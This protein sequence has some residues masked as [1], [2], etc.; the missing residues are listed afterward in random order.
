M[1]TVN[2]SLPEP[3]RRWVDEQ[4]RNGEYADA[5]EYVLE[6]IL[7]DRGKARDAD[8]SLDRRRRER[9]E[10]SA[11]RGDYCGRQGADPRWRNLRLQEEPT[12]TSRRYLPT[13]FASMAKS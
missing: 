8:P 6:L 10:L 12:A 13:L 2:V 5:S 9:N 11:A 1:T 4:V 3:I 7:E